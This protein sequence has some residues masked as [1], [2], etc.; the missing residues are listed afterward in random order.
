MRQHLNLAVV[1]FCFL[2]AITTSGNRDVRGFSGPCYLTHD[3]WANIYMLHTG[4]GGPYTGCAPARVLATP[5]NGYVI[6]LTKWEDSASWGAEQMGLVKLDP[7]GQVQ[8]AYSPLATGGDDGACRVNGLASLADGRLAAAARFMDS[9]DSEHTYIALAMLGGDGTV[10]WIKSFRGDD[11]YDLQPTAE[12][13]LLLAGRLENGPWAAK[14]DS[15]GRIVW[16]AG[17][18]A[19]ILSIQETS[20]GGFIGVG[21]SGSWPGQSSSNAWIVKFDALGAITWQK[22][23]G[24]PSAADNFHRVL[25][26]DDGYIAI[27]ETEG[28]GASERDAWAVKFDLQ[29]NISWQRAYGI[30]GSGH[31][32]WAGAIV[33]LHK[34][35]YLLCGA[36]DYGFALKL[37]ASGNILWGRKYAANPDDALETRQGDFVLIGDQILPNTCYPVG[38]IHSYYL[39]VARVDSQGMIGSGCC[40]IGDA[41]VV[42]R[43]TA[44]VPY[45]TSFATYHSPAVVG[46]F[47]P[48]DTSMREVDIYGVCQAALK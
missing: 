47:T 39:V 7:S 30:Q 9:Y 27:G 26:V 34:G 42:G 41:D 32:S 20:D 35:G 36:S 21:T 16:Q 43:T 3:H 24:D 12:G 46:S 10:Q 23:C 38:D 33:R 13:G 29:G 37:D 18:D 6:G 40:L 15:E 8:W 17:L 28:L 19:V 14:L 25:V 31:N 11:V 44:A 4:Y 5:D 48:S 1:F 45:A 2:G 22:S